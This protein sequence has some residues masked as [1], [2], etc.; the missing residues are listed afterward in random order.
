VLSLLHLRR[1]A[2]YATQIRQLVSVKEASRLLVTWLETEIAAVK[3]TTVPAYLPSAHSQRR[4][5]GAQVNVGNYGADALMRE[6]NSVR[7]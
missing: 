4:I 2:S 6:W 1:F 5:F 7:A 3:V